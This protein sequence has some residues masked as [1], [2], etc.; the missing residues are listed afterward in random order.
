[1]TDVGKAIDFTTLL[2][3]RDGDSIGKFCDIAA[4]CER[5]QF[6][7]VYVDGVE[8]SVV[9][10]WERSQPELYHKISRYDRKEVGGH[11]VEMAVRSTRSTYWASFRSRLEKILQ[12]KFCTSNFSEQ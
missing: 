5:S 12:K 10:N 3:I 2:A 9:G 7:K 8:F 6:Y 4:C 1:M 11:D